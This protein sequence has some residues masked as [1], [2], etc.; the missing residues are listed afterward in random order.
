[1][2]NDFRSVTGRF[3][4]HYLRTNFYKVALEGTAKSTVDSLRR[5]MFTGFPVAVP[6]SEEQASIVGKIQ[7]RAG[8]FDGL[9]AQATIAI[10]L[11]QE[12][13]SALISAAVTGQIDVRGFTAGGSEAA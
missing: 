1:M 12:R 5:P 9:V 6:P 2:M 7:E 11:L 3:L 8:Q 13:R 10:S 4:Y